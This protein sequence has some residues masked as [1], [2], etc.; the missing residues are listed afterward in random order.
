MSAFQ[1]HL[2]QEELDEALEEYACQSFPL[3]NNMYMVTANNYT[4]LL[5]LARDIPEYR[6][7]IVEVNRFIM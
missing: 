1:N 6:G 4:S 2:S 7:L 3:K 5:A